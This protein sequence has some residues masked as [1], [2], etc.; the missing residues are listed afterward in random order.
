LAKFFQGIA[1]VLGLHHFIAPLGKDSP[2]EFPYVGFI[3]Y[4]QDPS[5]L[6]L[7]CQESPRSN[8]AERAVGVYPGKAD[9]LLAS[10]L[11]Y[12]SSSI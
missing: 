4:H 5:H 9:E 11:I 6:R 2:Q 1:A 12:L 10:W 7:L 3:V 8:G